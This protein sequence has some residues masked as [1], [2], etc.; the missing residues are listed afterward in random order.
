MEYKYT[1]KFNFEIFA[2]DIV[3]LADLPTKEKSLASLNEFLPNLDEKKDIDL[4]SIAFNGA[5]VN[6]FNKND[7]GIS[8]ATAV[9]IIDYFKNKPINIEHDR[10]RIVGHITSAGFTD[11][12]NKKVMNSDEAMMTNDP[13][14]LSFGGYIYKLVNSEFYNELKNSMNPENE[15][16]QSI[17][18]SWE[19]GFNSY[20]IALGSSNVSNAKILDKEDQVEHYS[21]YLRS[22]GGEGFTE[23]GER[24]YRLIMGEVYPLGIGLVENPAA[25]VKGVICKNEEQ[26]L[27]NTDKNSAKSNINISNDTIDISQSDQN[28]VNNLD[29]LKNMEIL[30]QIKEALAAEKKISDEVIASV[31]SKFADAIKEYN[32][33]YLQQIQ[34]KEEAIANELKEKEDLK[35]SIADIES[36]L[37]AAQEQIEEFEAAKKQEAVAALINQRMEEI[38]SEYALDNDSRKT[39]LEDLA[40][41]DSD[42]AFA[43]YKNKLSIFL[44]DRT[45]EAIAK[46]QEE[47][48]AF[49]E[50][51]ASVTEE[52]PENEAIA[53]EALEEVQEE[54]QEVPNNSNANI[55]D[56]SLAQKFAKAFSK[57]NIVIS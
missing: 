33:K 21:K 15:M 32:E 16:F 47:K 55:E 28:V 49:E 27:P 3:K 1:T 22:F 38:D 25:D 23:S 42:E 6:M 26:S 29:S 45:K 52:V 18:A 20:A 17:S 7:D 39:I 2:A 46:A 30:N 31:T 4:L 24:V 10:S 37:A 51:Q 57:E 53:E 43:S 19:I 14:N 13:Y 41:L 34:E 35:Q 44:K 12:E 48:K 11:K 36:K 8:S 50:A 56:Q 40:G 5:V 54:Q 9:K